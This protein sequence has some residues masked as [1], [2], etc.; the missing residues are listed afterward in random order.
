MRNTNPLKLIGGKGY[1]SIGHLSGSRLGPSDSTIHFGQERILTEKARDKHDRII[2]TEKLD[3]SC[4]AQAL[5]CKR[6]HQSH[7]W[8]NGVAVVRG[9]FNPNGD[10]P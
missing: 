5:G 2:V 7:D 6:I 1:G 8:D 3:G 10:R 9:W 4:V